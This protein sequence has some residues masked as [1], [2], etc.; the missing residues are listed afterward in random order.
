[1]LTSSCLLVNKPEHLGQCL[2]RRILLAEGPPGR[3]HSTRGHLEGGTLPKGSFWRFL[4]FIFNYYFVLVAGAIG[5]LIV[6][7]LSIVSFRFF[8]IDFMLS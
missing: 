8:Q 6:L 4:Y 5:C 7:L 3:R 1:M 2:E